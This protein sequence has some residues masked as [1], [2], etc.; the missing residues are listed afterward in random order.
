ML[1]INCPYCGKRAQKEFTYAG[2]AS[3]K[4]PDL[5]AG[6]DWDWFEFVYLRD[7]PRGPHD[8]LWHHSAGCRRFIKVRRHVVTHEIIAT[9]TPIDNLNTDA[10]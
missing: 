2:D 9:G 4:R 5:E 8:E 10:S 3:T 6:T 7:N 1:E